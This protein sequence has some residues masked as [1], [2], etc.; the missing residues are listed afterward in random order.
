MAQRKSFPSNSAIVS[1]TDVASFVYCPEQW[2][3]SAL[4]NP[5]ENLASL[6]RWY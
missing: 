4:G 2:R 5:S 3:L 6:E 1:A